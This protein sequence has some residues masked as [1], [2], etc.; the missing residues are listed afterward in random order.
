[1][2]LRVF[3]PCLEPNLTV[4]FRWKDTYGLSEDFLNAKIDG[5]YPGIGDH[6][7]AV[8]TTINNIRVMFND[9]WE[10]INDDGKLCYVFL[11]VLTIDGVPVDLTTLKD[12]PVF[13][14]KID[15]APLHTI[16]FMLGVCIED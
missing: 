9:D 16:D 4:T 2:V 1:M 13:S 14:L 11:G 15:N 7:L 12:I 6:L 5:F 3:G 10:W 8:G